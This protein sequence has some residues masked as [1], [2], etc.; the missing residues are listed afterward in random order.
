MITNTVGQDSDLVFPEDVNQC[1]IDIVDGKAKSQN[2]HIF[3]HS[4]A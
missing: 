4:C 2:D 3:G 1:A